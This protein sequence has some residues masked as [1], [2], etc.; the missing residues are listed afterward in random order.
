MSAIIQNFDIV[1]NAIKTSADSAGSALKEN[2]KYLNSIQGKLDLFNNAVQ[3]MWTN[4]LNSDVIK[5]FVSLGT[6]IIKFVDSF[7]LIRSALAGVLV[8]FTAIKKNNPIT[9]IKDLGSNMVN[10]G[11]QATQQTIALKNLTVQQ[12]A[13]KMATAGLTQEEIKENLIKNNNISTD[14]AQLLAKEAVTNAKIKQT[15][16][17]A[18]GVL[19][20]W[21]E[22]KVTLSNA[23]ADWLEKQGTDELTRSKL[24]EAVATKA[25]TEQ[26]R[27]EIAAKYGLLSATESLKLGVKGLGATIKASMA[28]NPIGWIM[29]A[30]SAIVMLTQAIKN[31]KEESVRAVQETL[32]AYEQAKDTLK[33]HKETIDEIS[34]DYQ[35]LAKGVDNLGNNV[36]L[37]TEE[38]ERYNEI[39]NKIADMFPNMV[40]GYTS[41][42]NAIIAL[43]GNVEELTK[44][45]EKEANAARDALLVDRNKVFENFKNNTT[46]ADFWTG[47][48]KTDE[49]AFFEKILNGAKVEEFINSGTFS[50]AQIDTMLEDAGIDSTT[51]FSSY[52]KF[53]SE[54]QKNLTSIQAYYRT[55]IA[56]LNAES[57][58]IKTA[59]NAYLSQDFDYLKLSDKGKDFAQQIINGFNTEFYSQFDSALEME[60][61]VTTNLIQPLQDVNK[62]SEFEVAFN[63]KTQ[64]NNGD[65]PA[66][67]YQ[68]KFQGFVDTLKELGFDDNIV[69]IVTLIFGIE[70]LTAKIESAKELLKPEDQD[71]ANQLTKDELEIVDKYKSAWGL[72]GDILLSWDALKEKIAAV[73]NQADDSS[74]TD[75]LSNIKSV[76][77]AYDDL[78]NALKEFREEGIA[79][80]ST[81]DSLNEKFKD[82]DG[83]EEL[84]KVLATGE[85]DVE[86]AITNVANAYIAQK[87]ILSDLTDDELD[88]MKNRLRELGVLNANEVI[89]VRKTA[90]S[91]LDAQLK[92][93]NI[94]LS[95]YAT[96]EEAKIAIAQQQG[97]D[98]SKISD[99]LLDTCI[100]NYGTELSKY[101]TMADKK[102]AIARYMAKETAKAALDA[103]Y[104]EK[105]YTYAE[106]YRS[107][108]YQNRLREITEKYATP[109]NASAINEILNEYYSKIFSFDLSNF[110]IGSDYKDSIDDAF[111]KRMDYWEN[112]I[113]ANQAKYEQI[114]NEI[115]LIEKRGGKAGTEYY[116]EQKKLEEERGVLLTKQLADAEARLKAIEDAGQTAS[117]IWWDVAKTINDLQNELDDVTS[118]IQDLNDAIAEIDTY[119]FE[120]THNRVKNLIND[121]DTIRDLIAQN[122]EEDWFDDEGMWTE[123]GVAVLSTYIQQYE[124]YKH[125]LEGVNEELAKYQ[126]EYAGNEAYYAELGIDSEQELYD[127]QRE[128]IDQQYEYAQAVNDTENSVKDAYSAQID[129]I[130]DWANKAV[131]AYNDYIDVVKESL[132]AERELYEFKKST[133]EKTK[134]I[135]Q[136]ERRIAS[137]AGADDAASIAERKKLQA[138][139]TD[140]KTD[141]EDHYYSHSMDAREQALDDEAKAYE[142][143]MNNYI[144]KLR[145]MLDEATVN[146]E[147]FMQSVTSAVMLNADAVKQEY[148]KTGVALEG[149]IISP[150]DEAITAM[151]KFNQD[152]LVILNSWTTDA[153]NKLKSPWSEGTIAVNTFSTSVDTAMKNIVTQVETNVAKA[154]E[155]L[156]SLYEDIKTTNI[157]Y[158]GGG[159]K[160]NPDGSDKTEQQT[161]SSGMIKALQQII[162]KFFGGM[163]K[164]DGKMGPLTKAALKI[165]QKIIG[166]E[167]TGEYD[168]KTYDALI[169]WLN[170]RP[171]GA[172]F[173]Q[174]GI[175][176]PAPMYAKG[177]TGTKKDQW[178][179]T[180]EPQFGDELTMYATPEGTLSYMRAGSTVTPAALTKEI[181]DIANVGLDGLMN[182]NKFGTNINMISN[183]INKPELNFNVEKFLSIDKVDEGCLPEVKKFVQQ[184]LDSFVRKLNYSL[185]GIGA[186]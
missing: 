20:D 162:N 73:Q 18:A 3:T 172:W 46:K 131:D 110:G 129:A 50:E 63:L 19:S 81:L 43:K 163:L 87:G 158:A 33:S 29:M 100:K 66:D 40:S 136:L 157:E 167:Q 115:D 51:W 79:S 127:K 49:L 12:Q 111:Q 7:G 6:E 132:S 144:E 10:A 180:D 140:A 128:L 185:K 92:G 130:E 98:F 118:S 86:K 72:D 41:E 42:G 25:I 60:A 28:S 159:E 104:D 168:K 113:S 96:A 183:A 161:S 146:M 107:Q 52:K 71:K 182:A 160:N 177:T 181:M 35:R 47:F 11:L 59:L 82:I 76:E 88:I 137:L 36:S 38:Y 2:E 34:D 123:K 99:E 44:A 135:A 56:T 24:L 1:E 58:S 95:M 148:E 32:S 64:F 139:L 67:E 93:Y 17:T 94:D 54:I 101:A 45:Y 75:S 70:D 165:M 14:R 134:N 102:I 151:E 138:E 80:A 21:A 156:S 55:L 149:A 114:Q 65:V 147:T 78:G 126:K 153:T 109:S 176:V 16:V 15:S 119:V 175:S 145:D 74:I 164:V 150:W 5:F 23:T 122:G 91:K 27:L 121:L 85:G 169:K 90:Q 30:I 26:D 124:M 184:E 53:N 8:Y 105:G 83:F 143:S 152:G 62:L 120:E 178:A 117:D 112:Q 77:E 170:A 171:V 154:K 125:A 186:R 155:S 84:Y 106:R 69:K 13:A 31:A 141:L 37:S 57:A 4:T 103:E 97:L 116:K 39:T 89:S 68:K 166:V 108:E 142:E 133:T 173:Q 61:W 22:N 48:S 174:K 9:I 179:I